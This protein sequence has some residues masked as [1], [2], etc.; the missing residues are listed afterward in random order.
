MRYSHSLLGSMYITQE[1]VIYM[2]RGD[3]T[4]PPG[5]SGPGT[6]RRSG[7]GIGR[8]AGRVGGTRPGAGPGGEC[9]CPSCGA[10]VAHQAGLPCNQRNCPKCGTLMARR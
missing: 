8:G 1:G 7:R 6:G 4:G 3:G 10:T 9:M 5:G 2:P